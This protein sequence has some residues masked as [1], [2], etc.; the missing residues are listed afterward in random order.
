MPLKKRKIEDETFLQLDGKIYITSMKNGRVVK[1]E[2]IDGQLV[3]KAIMTIIRREVEKRSL[4]KKES[5][6]AKA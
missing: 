6:L 4:Q 5:K 3:L 2:E 1:R